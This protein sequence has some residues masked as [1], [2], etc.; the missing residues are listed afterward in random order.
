[1]TGEKK[2]KLII[3][4]KKR[5]KETRGA[6][7]TEKRTE[8]N[9][10]GKEGNVDESFLF[11]GEKVAAG[12]N[13]NGIKTEGYTIRKQWEKRKIGTFAEKRGRGQSLIPFRK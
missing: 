8:C 3:L 4:F 2:E 10:E 5:G 9:P 1:L 12:G 13:P 7:L 11:I 6:R